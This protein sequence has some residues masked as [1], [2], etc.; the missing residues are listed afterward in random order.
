MGTLI[1][2]ECFDHLYGFFDFWDFSDNALMCANELPFCKSIAIVLLIEECEYLIR[3]V[4]AG[5][6]HV[7]LG[8]RMVTMKIALG[9]RRSSSIRCY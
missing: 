9:I 1:G 6:L 3:S 7:F 8:G 5:F 4:S 2:G